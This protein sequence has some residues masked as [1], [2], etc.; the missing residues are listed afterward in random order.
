[1]ARLPTAYAAVAWCCILSSPTVA[2]A[3]PELHRSCA[4]ASRL[5]ASH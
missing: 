2:G 3:V 5:P 4:P 1:M